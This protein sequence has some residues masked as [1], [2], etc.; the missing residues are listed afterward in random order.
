MMMIID[1]KTKDEIEKRSRLYDA[2][3]E[4]IEERIRS[5]IRTAKEKLVIA[6]RELLNE[7]EI[8]F[9][10]NPFAKLL[11]EINS[12]NPHIDMAVVKGVLAEEVSQH[13]GPS[14]ESFYSLCREIERFKEWRIKKE[15]KPGIS[16]PSNV[17]V[18]S[19]TQDSITLTWDDDWMA[20]FY[21]IEVDGSKSLERV[22]TNSFTKRGLLAETDHTF[23]IRGMNWNTVSEW[24]ADVK[25]RTG[26]PEFSKCVWKECPDNVEEKRKYSVN[27]KNTRVAT[28]IGSGDRCTIIGNTPLPLSK[29]TS[30]SI[31]VLKSKGGIG[32]GIFIG[33]APSDINQNENDNCKKCGWYF[34]CCD[35]TLLSGPP[36]NH[37]WREYGPRK[38]NGQYIQVGGSVGVVM[39][40]AKGELSFAL[41]G[42]NLGVAYE[43][44][45]L[46]KP[47]VPCVLLWNEGDSVELVI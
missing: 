18:E 7:V 36:H 23:R 1:A 27:K 44:I 6:E 8:E 28:K 10:E 26:E 33:V 42:V 34:Y 21:Q 4:K 22:A 11:E 17:R 30:W 19:A 40:T 3:K 29:V 13:F 24:S 14:E 16:S 25:G 2:T 32:N 15:E 47:L 41:N 37:R 20:L 12:G 46:G 5:N 31:K 35:S 45:P 38:R 39:D 43:E 9:G